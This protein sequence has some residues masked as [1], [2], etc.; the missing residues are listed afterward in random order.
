MV[1]TSRHLTTN[2]GITKKKVF[3]WILFRVSLCTGWPSFTKPLEPNNII[4]KGSSGFLSVS[5]QVRSR[6]ADSFLGDV[7]K[8]GPKPTGL[9]YCMNSAALQFIPKNELE[10]RGYG[11]YAE[12]FNEQ[13]SSK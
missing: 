3:T 12:Q 9:R 8:D 6:N 1:R 5:T 10:K 2:I 4:L 7:F 11:V 13:K